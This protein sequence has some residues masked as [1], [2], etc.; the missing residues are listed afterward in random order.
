MASIP[1]TSS[2]ASRLKQQYKKLTRDPKRTV[3]ATFVVVFAI[4]GA[5]LLVLS[6]AATTVSSVK[7]GRWSDPSVWSNNRVPEVDDVVTVGHAVTFDLTVSPR[8]ADIYI[9]GSLV[10]DPAKTTKLVTNRNI[11]VR[12]RLVMEPANPN[13]E[14]FIQFV[15]VD[16]RA[17]VGGGMDPA[18]TPNDVGMWVIGDG[19]LQIAGSSKTSWTSMAGAASQGAT[20]VT[21]KDAPAGWR[22][23]DTIMIAPNE[24]PTVGAQ[25]YQGF[26]ERVITG[27]SG[28]TISFA[29]GLS[30]PKLLVNNKWTA[31]VGNLSRNVRIEGTTTPRPFENDWEDR[32]RHNGNSHILIHSTKTQMISNA[33]LRYMGSG[34]VDEAIKQPNFKLGR[35][36]IHMHMMGEASRGSVIDG[37][38]VRD[39]N[40]HSFV[41]HASNGVTLR[42]NIAYKV[43]SAAFWWDPHDL[44]KN[45][46]S[47]DIVW[48]HNLVANTTPRHYGMSFF[49]L[50]GVGNKAINNVAVGIQGSG[51]QGGF[52]WF[53]GDHGV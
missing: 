47:H 32:D 12:G 40:F 33:Q 51:E 5:S 31:E 14:Q 50:G 19:Q 48:D 2:L 7:D 30:R 3:M 22:V 11:V 16:E 6:R 29:Q 23:G 36:A 39:A 52:A 26:D 45:S 44:D 35:Y 10:F 17:F 43:K 15:E 25:S 37:V 24:P 38:V 21:L 49:L 42:N 13:V 1:R 28:N 27:I 34:G 4:T 41:T 9:N 53:N 46:D 20:S 18:T 8:M